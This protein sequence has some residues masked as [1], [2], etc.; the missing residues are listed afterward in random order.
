MRPCARWRVAAGAAAL[1]LLATAGAPS[2][3]EAS[4]PSFSEFLD[5]VRA[6]ALQRGIRQEIIDA[7]LSNIQEPLPV[8]IERDRSQAETVLSLE[9]YVTRRLTPK[10]V[11]RGRDAFLKHRA[12]LDEVAGRYGV[13][14]PVIV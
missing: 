10:L 8:V 6:E 11:R 14:A 13:P 9:D 7:S 2:A 1:V 3:Q 5:G 4:R 12:L